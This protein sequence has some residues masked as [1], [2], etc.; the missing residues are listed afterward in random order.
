MNSSLSSSSVSTISTLPNSGTSAQRQPATTPSAPG[1]ARPPAGVARRRARS[2]AG[3]CASTAKLRQRAAARP[4]EQHVRSRPPAMYSSSRAASSAPAGYRGRRPSTPTG[5]TPAAI[6]GAA[7]SR[8]RPARRSGA[9]PRC[10][11][12]AAQV[13]L[14]GEEVGTALVDQV[15]LETLGRVVRRGDRGCRRACPSNTDRR[16]RAECRAPQLR[17][18]PRVT[19]RGQR[20]RPEIGAD[21]TRCPRRS[22]RSWLLASGST[23][24][25][26]TN[27]RVVQVELAHHH[28]VRAA[29]GQLQQRAPM[30]G[31]QRL[32]ALP[33][34]VLA[35]ALGQRVQVQQHAPSAGDSVRYSAERGAPPQTARVR[36][37]LP[38]VVEVPAAADHVGDPV[39]RVE[40]VQDLAP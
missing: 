22:S 30:T 36:R 9:A 13:V 32:R 18:H 33:H 29:P 12:A 23:K 15:A 5:S 27:V 31:P 1:G 19:R 10:R 25:S 38:E 16:R 8:R 7:R 39:V 34:P 35:L 24:P 26:S 4:A 6:R 3:G 21:D 20:I 11:R 28:R 37:V 17:D 40:A 2:A 14:G